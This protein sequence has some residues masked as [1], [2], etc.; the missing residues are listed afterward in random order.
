M[1]IIMNSEAI[2]HLPTAFGFHLGYIVVAGIASDP[3]RSLD[4]VTAMTAAS[5]SSVIIIAL[6]L[7][8]V[9]VPL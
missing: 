3:A 1:E 5:L 8:V 4:V 7:E 6:E 9:D 2:L